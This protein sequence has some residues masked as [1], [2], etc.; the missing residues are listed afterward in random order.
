MMPIEAIRQRPASWERTS[1]PTSSDEV[2]V[3]RC[4]SSG[5]VPS[6]FTRWTPF[7]DRDSSTCESRSARFRWRA[8]V[9]SR[10]IRATLRVS[11]TAGGNTIR[12]SSERRQL[13]ATMAPDVPTTPVTFEAIDVAVDVTTDCMPPMSFV[14][15]DCTSPPRVRV[16][17]PS[18]WRC[19]WSKTC[20][21]MPCITAWPTV[22]D[23][24][25]CSTPRTEV[26]TVTPSMPA[27]SQI[28]RLTFRCGSATSIRSRMRNGV[29]SETTAEA[30][31][32]SMT[33]TT[34]QR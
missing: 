15:R 30:V 31:I 14:N 22:V 9:T 21:R 3:N 25:V 1:S 19:R 18:D 12:E 16:K 5:P 28:S 13:S 6:V 27:T 23:S 29:A 4:E 2:A 33:A 7:T 20:V 34:D 26:T 11:H 8:A 10:R 17:K 24:Q 32:S